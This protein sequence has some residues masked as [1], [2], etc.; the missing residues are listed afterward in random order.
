MAIR[1]DIKDPR[2]RRALGLDYDPKYDRIF[3][4][5]MGPNRANRDHIPGL[6]ILGVPRQPWEDRLAEKM[7]DRFRFYP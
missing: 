5:V 1:D 3:E 4:I 2:I 6:S 7:P